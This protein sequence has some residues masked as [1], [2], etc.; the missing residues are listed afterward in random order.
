MSKPHIDFF[1]TF[2]SELLSGLRFKNKFMRYWG[3]TYIDG[4][5]VLNPR[6][7]I[8][9][10]TES[11]NVQRM[12]KLLGMQ[13]QINKQDFGELVSFS[14]WLNPKKKESLLDQEDIN[15]LIAGKINNYI[16]INTSIDVDIQFIDEA[17]PL[18]FV[19][20]DKEQILAYVDSSYDTIYNTLTVHATGDTLVTE[21]IGGYL[22]FD[23]GAHF[24]IVVNN[25]NVMPI[26]NKTKNVD[27]YVVGY[28]S[29][30]NLNIT[31]TR[32]SAVLHNSVLVSKIVAEQNEI[33]I[34]ATKQL[35]NSTGN[36][37]IYNTNWRRASKI[38]DDVWYKGYFRVEFL[39]NQALKSKNRIK[40]L[41]D[42][43]D[44][45]QVQ[46]KA[47]GWK[48]WLG[49]IL[50]IAAVLLAP[51]TGGW[52]LTVIAVNVGIATLIMIAVQVYW[53][54]HG[55]AAAAQY[56]GRWVQIGSIVSV[57]TGIAAAIQN[58][59]RQ[60]AIEAFKTAAMAGGA[61]AAEVGIAT[62]GMTTAEISAATVAMGGAEA[63]IG[64]MIGTAVESMW[65]SVSNSWA[66]TGLKVASAAIN[67]RT[68]SMTAK[69][70][71]NYHE[72]EGRAADSEEELA[73]LYDKELS[74]GLED[75]KW[76]TSPIT[77]DK[78]QFETD[79]LYEGTKFNI[80]RPSFFKATGL[81]IISD[82]VYK[83]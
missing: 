13:E 3:T 50:M 70:E 24:D 7:Q 75:I 35:V 18:K 71:A 12:L 43:L 15:Y 68:N 23:N 42:V 73:K 67:M 45:Q 81:N 26:S 31:A 51:V 47:H 48:K 14:L 80:G 19:G 8:Y 60:A 28:T 82:D 66:T 38:T 20:W 83:V 56:M 16:P 5:H 78:L 61:T 44:T 39:N 62:A 25:A 29:G 63:S 9:P 58:L 21:A 33:K 53:A 57:A 2:K 72:L 69:M 11:L 36:D 37:E 30:I 6:F 54:K 52:S 46:P 65:A 74:I 41:T 49:P 1:E 4:V 40:I 76:Y 27:E 55:D 34:E 64:T 32:R 10:G 17:D 59:S 77:M 22:L 79:Y